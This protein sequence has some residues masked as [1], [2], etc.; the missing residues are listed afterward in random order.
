M[1]KYL[2][3][4]ETTKINIY[5]LNYLLNNKNKKINTI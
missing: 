1:D 2:F 3:L 4:L 5:L